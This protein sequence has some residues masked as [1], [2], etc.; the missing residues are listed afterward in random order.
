MIPVPVSWVV[1]CCIIGVLSGIGAWT[2][3]EDVVTDKLPGK[4]LLQMLAFIVVMAVVSFRL[5]FQVGAP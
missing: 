1:A 5:V 4:R 2:V 3:V